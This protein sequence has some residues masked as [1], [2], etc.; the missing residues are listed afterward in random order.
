MVGRS[1]LKSGRNGG[2]SVLELRVLFYFKKEHVDLE[3]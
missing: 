2:E 1:C 3:D